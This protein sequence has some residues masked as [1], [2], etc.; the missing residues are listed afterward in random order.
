MFSQ[1]K[2]SKVKT[3]VTSSDASSSSESDLIDSDLDNALKDLEIGHL[4]TAQQRRPLSRQQ[5]TKRQESACSEQ[6]STNATNQWRT[7]TS[8]DHPNILPPVDS[9]ISKTKRAYLR[10]SSVFEQAKQPMCTNKKQAQKHHKN[11]IEQVQIA[12]QSGIKNRS[13]IRT[14]KNAWEEK[15]ERNQQSMMHSFKLDSQRPFIWEKAA[16]RAILSNA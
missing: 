2:Y 16:A 4:D 6:T 9:S 3:L 1:P 10:T 5:Q 13:K 14:V 15:K 8:L 12:I 7:R 11:L